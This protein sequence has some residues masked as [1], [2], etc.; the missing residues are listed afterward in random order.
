MIT[1]TRLS[2]PPKHHFYGYYGIEA[3]DPSLR[4]HLS[5]ETDFH[6]H[7]PIVGDVTS[8]GVIDGET[9][10]FIPYASTSAFNLQQG[11]MMH[12]IDVGF[13][14]EFTFNDW[15]NDGL[16][17]RA[18][19]LQTRNTRTIHGAIAA[20]SPTQP[21]A[22]GLNFARMAHCRAVVGYANEMDPNSLQLHPAD[23]GLF[24]LDLREGSSNL[25]LSI[26]DVIRESWDAN[27]PNGLAWFNHVLFNID[28]TRVLFFCR[29]R[30]G[31]GFLSSLWTV[32]P[33]GSNLV[34]QIP[35]GNKV[36]H[37]YWRD[38][39]SILISSDVTG[40][41]QFLEFTD[42]KRDFKPFGAGILPRDGHASF[43]PDRNWIVC[44]AYPKNP[45]RLAELMLY[46][47]RRERKIGLGQFYS[48]EIFTGDIRCDLH[49]RWSSDGKMI[50]FDSVHEDS[51][52]IYLLDVEEIVSG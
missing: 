43:S 28:G 27:I 15:E 46:D 16:V 34:C 18:I 40:E 32:N 47:I 19:N 36:S 29:I 23:D 42:G 35:F 25:I 45:Q 5:L 6:E 49:P 17:S 10:A 4:Y 52:Q 33:D 41:I 9:H 24:L 14:D 51:R 3:W 1:I 7:R 31:D 50:T 21:V 30:H 8:V 38:E 12:W 26:A 44:D 11:S 22:L 13:G 2:S 20:L 48:E 37:F 39:S